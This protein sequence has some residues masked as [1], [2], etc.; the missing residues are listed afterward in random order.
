MLLDAG[1]TGTPGL[2]AL[3]GG[4]ALDSELARR[5]L[6]RVASLWNMYGP[7]E[8][9]VWSTCAAITDPDDIDIGAPVA[10]TVVYVVDDEGQL[11][12]PGVTGEL[13]IGGAGVAAGYLHQRELTAERFVPDPIGGA[14]GARVYR[15]GDLVRWTHAGHLRYVG[16]RDTQVKVRGHRIELGE[17][18]AAL[19]THPAIARAVAVVSESA[20]DKRI[21]AYF[22]P[23]GADAPTGSELRTHL[24]ARLPEPMVPHFFVE[25]GALPL[26][27]NGK[28]DRRALPAPSFG[29]AP[30]TEQVAPRTPAELALAALWRELLDVDRVSVRDNFFDLG[31]HS[32]LATQLVAR[33]RRLHGFEI[34][35]RAVIFESLEQLAAGCG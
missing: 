13:L 8:T 24:R 12:P 23:R 26:T 15:T 4:E 31:G 25:L 35:P 3:C 28:V 16:R 34:S 17:I 5:L 7:T 32:L 20:G 6:P 30:S 29:A 27:D 22:V 19:A 33:A 2:R 14:P 18:E 9:T 21:V 1:W 10:N 11:V